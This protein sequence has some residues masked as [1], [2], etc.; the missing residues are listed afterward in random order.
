MKD[1][2]GFDWSKIRG[3][4]YW[5]KPMLGRRMFFRHIASAVGGYVTGRMRTKWVNL[6]THEVFFRDTAHGL[7]VWA[8]GTVVSIGLLAS[9]VS[10]VVSGAAQVGGAALQGAGS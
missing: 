5:S 6:H 1:R 8:V 9:A 4:P 7:L 10:T 3:A 2:F